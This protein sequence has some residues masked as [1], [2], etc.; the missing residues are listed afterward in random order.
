MPP[1]VIDIDALIPATLR[2]RI[3][4]CAGRDELLARAGA[5]DAW[6]LRLL[7][8]VLPQTLPPSA[9]K[10]MRDGK[11]RAIATRLRTVLPDATGHR[12]AT[13]IAAAGITLS[14]T[15][16]ALPDARFDHMADSERAWMTVEVHQVLSWGARWPKLRQIITIIG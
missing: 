14:T 8:M 13:L 15:G 3:F 7:A 10:A 9:I 11:I 1:A 2:D 16:C 12:I 6:A 5:G 4:A